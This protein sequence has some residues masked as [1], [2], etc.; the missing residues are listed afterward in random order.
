M[1][2]DGEEYGCVL[3]LD[4]RGKKTGMP[5]RRRLDSARKNISRRDRRGGG[6]ARQSSTENIIVH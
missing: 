5:K 2:T 4:M 1:R 6:S 3:D